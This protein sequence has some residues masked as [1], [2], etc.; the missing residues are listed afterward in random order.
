MTSLVVP[1]NEPMRLGL[2]GGTFDPIHVGHIA[3]AQAACEACGIDEVLFIPA[4]VP[5]FKRGRRLA[6]AET[7]LAWCEAS[8]REHAHFHACDIEIKRDGITY[9]V[10]TLRQLR[11][12]YASDVELCFILGADS[13]ASLPRWYASEELAELATFVAVSRPGQALDEEVRSSLEAAGFRVEYAE[14]L[15]VDVSSSD[16][17]G[18]I[19]SG[20]SIEGLVP[21]AIRLQVESEPA[22]CGVKEAGV[23]DAV[24]PEMNARGGVADDAL[25]DAFFEARKAEL[26]GRVTEK[27]FNHVMGVVD[28]AQR[29]AEIYDV[30]V[31]TARLA[32]LL[33]D[34]DKGYD[35]EGIWKRGIDLGLDKTLDPWVFSNMPQVLHAHTAAVALEQE[36]P[37]IPREV[38]QAIDRHTVGDENMTPLEMVLYCADAIEDGRRFGTIDELRAAVGQVSLDELFFRV[39][40]FWT[41]NL[42]SRRHQV[43]P[44]TIKVWN[45]LIA[46]RGSKKGRE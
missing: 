3:C 22:Y 23:E 40:E 33:H 14:G 34:W 28:A 11:A 24:C 37:Q 1:E 41:L 4:S 17:R 32:A 10:D 42:L 35:D 16:I 19:A 5:N 30:D 12:L 44:A 43:H 15:M 39:Y 21:E 25:S 45:T 6:P 29:L 31:R 13:A 18:R 20:E 9:T 27:R 26:V 38:I 7:R 36:F 46:R 2:M 8:L